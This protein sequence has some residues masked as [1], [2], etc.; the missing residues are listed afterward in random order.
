MF[1]SKSYLLTLTSGVILIL[2]LSLSLPA[3]ALNTQEENVFAPGSPENPYKIRDWYELDEVR[4]ELDASY[5]LVNDLNEGTHG[6][7]EFVDTGKGWKPLGNSSAGFTGCFDGN[8]H[9]IQDIYINRSDG[10]CVGLFGYSQGDI[11]NIG[12]EEVDVTG[13]W[14][15]GGLVGVNRGEVKDSYSTGEVTGV[16]Y[17]VGGLIG[18]NYGDVERSYSAADVTGNGYRVGGLIGNHNFADV[19]DTYASGTVE[20]IFQVGGLIGWNHWG[21]VSNSYARGAVSGGGNIGGLIGQNWRGYVANSFWDIE[22]S[23]IDSSAGGTGKNT[24]EM[25]D[26]AT[27]TDTDTEGLEW[28]WDFVGYPGDEDIWDIDEGI[29]DGYPFFPREDHAVEVWVRIDPST[30]NLRSNGNWVTAYIDL[31]DIDV[32]TVT[33]GY[34]E[35]KVSAVWGD[36]QDVMM[37]K[38]HMSE[39]QDMLEPGEV[40]LII[41]GNTTEGT[42]F[43]GYDTIRVIDPGRGRAR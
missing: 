9:I 6:Y 37:V 31:T 23:G 42:D 7:D 35:E 8:H 2:I 22:T 18:L 36:E 4:Y 11:K 29:N 17:D 25:K 32:N 12:L 1:G 19:V 34:D 30:L 3:S 21:S 40:E 41:E 15:V 24:E 16:G 43:L 38:F 33:L 13:D 28:A 10:W 27:F 39:V 26:V 5:E 14:Y 20:G